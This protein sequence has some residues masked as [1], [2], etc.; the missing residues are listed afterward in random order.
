M[1]DQRHCKGKPRDNSVPMKEVHEKETGRDHP[2]GRSGETKEAH[3]EHPNDV[4]VGPEAHSGNTLRMM[5]VVP[6][7]PVIVPRSVP[8]TAASSDMPLELL[9]GGVTQDLYIPRE[10]PNGFGNLMVFQYLSL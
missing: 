4:A 1:R 3:R 2:N 8:H 5:L 9:R 6:S 7:V 10:M